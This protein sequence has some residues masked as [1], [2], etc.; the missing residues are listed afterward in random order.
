MTW[1]Q[2]QKSTQAK[3]SDYAKV[4][5]ALGDE[6]PAGLVYHAAGEVEGGTWQSVSVWESEDD[7]NRFREQRLDSAAR[8]ALGDEMID[9]GPPPTE[10]FEAKD[11][12]KPGG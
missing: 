12:W 6:P 7:F 1:V 8:D 9:A 5:Q 4:R 11:I 10:S 3:W 2:I